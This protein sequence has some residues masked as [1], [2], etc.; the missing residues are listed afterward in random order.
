MNKNLVFLLIIFSIGTMMVLSLQSY[1]FA[2]T[3]SSD[4]P[5]F[6][7]GHTFIFVQ[8]FVHNSQGQLVTYIASDKFSS[9]NTKAL[10]NLLDFEQ[11]ENDPIININGEKFQV[12][13][14]QVTIPYEKE[15]VIASTIIAHSTKG[16]LNLVARFAHD[17]Y[18][19]VPGDKVTT[20][21][22]FIRPLE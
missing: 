20:V 16:V 11:S 8:T 19:L 15:N 5:I 18:P 2:Q 12:I 7:Q 1:S 17:G 21:W 13:K 22:T 4:K 10:K 3:S 6:F 14:R 9:I